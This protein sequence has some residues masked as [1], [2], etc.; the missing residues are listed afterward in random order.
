MTTSAPA[1]ASAPELAK[2]VPVKLFHTAGHTR[3]YR[4]TVPA[5]LHLR[6]HIFLMVRGPQQAP[7]Y[8]ALVDVGSGE[9]PSWDGLQ[10]GLER[11][12]REWEENVDLGRLDRIVLTHAHPD[13]IGGLDFF[14]GP[15]PPLAAHA[16]A[17]RDIQEPGWQRDWA[18]QATQTFLDWADI[19]GPH[20]DR[21]RRRAGRG[22]VVQGRP[23]ATVLQ[24]GDKLD[25]LMEVIH[26]PG[27]SL[28]QLCL[29]IDDVLLSAD[30]VLARNLPPLRSEKIDPGDT[31]QAY[32]E[33]LDK[34]AALDIRL[35][36]GSHDEEMTQW[37]QRIARIREK[38]QHK[39]EQALMLA[40]HPITINE[41]CRAMNPRMTE[42]QAILLLDQ[43]AAVAEYLL[44]RG[45]LAEVHEGGK[46]KVVALEHLAKE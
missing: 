6:V 29:K 45:Q 2:E 7:E 35:M 22:Y 39:Q 1:Q 13:H 23:I 43:V 3:I 14:E 37:P 33:S 31:L 36:L 17:V 27:H 16:L 18:L 4:I 20:A 41:L 32:L 42:A 30:Q 28:G 21:M 26:T 34:L 10:R 9:Q 44:S 19:A 25:G 12:R 46:T 15:L 8:T 11:I 38:Y 24:D 5:F 40:Q